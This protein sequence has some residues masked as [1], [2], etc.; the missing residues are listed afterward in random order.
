M[1]RKSGR[2]KKLATAINGAAKRTRRRLPRGPATNTKSASAPSSG[3]AVHLTAARTPAPSTR[4]T[5]GVKR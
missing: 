3:R 5:R 2:S 4:D 1:K